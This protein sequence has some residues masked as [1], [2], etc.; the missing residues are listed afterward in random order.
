MKTLDEL[1]KTL[2]QGDYQT[3]LKDSL[4]YIDNNSKSH[5]AHYLAAQACSKLNQLE[6][7]YEHI[8]KAVKIEPKSDKYWQNLGQILI[9]QQEWKKAR[10]AFKQSLKLNANLF[11]SYLAL[12]DLDIMESNLN[13]AKKQYQMA[14]KVHE[15]GLP[16]ILR[17]ARVNILKGQYSSVYDEMLKLH[18]QFPQE[19]SITLYLG[20]TKYEL[21]ETGI[22]EFYFRNI[23]K[24]VPENRLAQLY[25]AMTIAETLPKESLDL[26]TQSYENT[27]QSPESHAAFG[28]YYLNNQQFKDA[29]KHLQKVAANPTATPSW[30][31]AYATALYRNGNTKK[32]TELLHELQRQTN[33][34]GA[35]MQ[36]AQLQQNDENFAAALATYGNIILLSNE[37]NSLIKLQMGLCEFHLKKYD[38]AIKNFNEVLAEEPLNNMAFIYKLRSLMANG[39]HKD[40]FVLAS[41]VKKENFST[42]QIQTIWRYTGLILDRQGDY[43]NAYDYFKKQTFNRK[44]YQLK[45]LKPVNTKIEEIG[46][47]WSYQPVTG[48]DF[49]PI[50]LMGETE[51]GLK[52]FIQWLKDNRINYFDRI[53]PYL[54]HRDFLSDQWSFEELTHISDTEIYLLR[55][56]YQ[57]NMQ[58]LYSSTAHLVDILPC[59]P[60]LAILIKRIYPDA[61]LILLSRNSLDVHLDQFIHGPG[62]IY[63][64]QLQSILNQIIGL[65]MSTL[66][67]DFDQWID[68]DKQTIKK[69]SDLL[70][71]QFSSVSVEKTLL[72]QR[73]MIKS[74]HWRNYKKLKFS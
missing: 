44:D 65:G 38:N 59:N 73:S 74:G 58:R 54:N 37:N 41:E 46:R 1:N 15:D 56:K 71:T 16:A 6:L 36:L 4:K 19:H 20:I 55:K 40:A 61:Q 64:D 24:Q 12:G 57:K 72:Y 51:T 11:F 63:S 17:L 28:I 42:E 47:S 14:L 60:L 7:A 49:H 69:L 27:H 34:K 23:L 2:Q 10:K 29:E 32:A 25:L 52:Q 67:V 8:Q 70:N 18:T 68:N 13:N 26:I 33:Q 35:L 43:E 48:N 53:K 3:T 31:I 50:F 45:T 5:Q 22:A 21:G 66:V 39:N 30:I 62:N 9:A